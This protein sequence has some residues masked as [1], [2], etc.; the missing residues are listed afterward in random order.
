MT[1]IERIRG[2]RDILAALTAA[3]PVYRPILD[4]LD[5]ELRAAERAAEIAASTL[6]VVGRRAKARAA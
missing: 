2:A 5:D 4:R 3:D 1:P 6:L